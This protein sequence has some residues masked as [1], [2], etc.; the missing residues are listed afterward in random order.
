MSKALQIQ[1]WFSLSG[2]FKFECFPD[3][4]E[5]AGHKSSGSTK[6]KC[7]LIPGEFCIFLCFPLD[8][9]TVC[10]ELNLKVGPVQI[11]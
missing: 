10:I 8:E 4:F 9:K 1:S 3:V 7:L 11:K 2:R 5:G 6:G